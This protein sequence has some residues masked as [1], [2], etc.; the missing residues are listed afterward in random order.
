MIRRYYILVIICG[1]FTPISYA[2]ETFDD[3]MLKSIGLDTPE[4][5]FRRGYNELERGNY[6]KAINYLMKAHKKGSLE[7]SYWI[8]E[9]LYNGW[10]IEKDQRQSLEYIQYAANKGQ[11]D[12]CFVLG[13]WY[14]NG[15]EIGNLT[16]LADINRGMEWLKI[17]SDKNHSDAQWYLGDCYYIKGDYE[18]AF[19]WYKKS[20]DLNNLMGIKRV[21]VRLMDGDGVIQDLVLAERYIMQAKRL[22]KGD[23]NIDFIIGKLYYRQKKYKDAAEMFKKYYVNDP[24][25]AHFLGS[26]YAAMASSDNDYVTALKYWEIASEGEELYGMFYTALCYYD[27]LGCEKD[28]NKAAMLFNKILNSNGTS[29][30]LNDPNIG[31]YGVSA[32][33]LSTCFRYGRGVEQN[34]EY[35]ERLQNFSKKTGC[36]ENTIRQI[37]DSMKNH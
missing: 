26:C 11:I 31:V 24:E 8:G 12:A 2:Q 29:V 16:I 18:T 17:A 30:S 1:L 34:I 20:A 21:G 15:V 19:K 5:Y 10:G 36:Y 27:G 3:H 13:M 28:Y 37:M 14:C 25:A 7:A 33:F 4:E 32:K 9:C 22:S 6:D 35:S 23:D